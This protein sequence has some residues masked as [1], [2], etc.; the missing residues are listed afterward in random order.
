MK[1]ISKIY[2]LLITCFA[3]VISYG[4]QMYKPAHFERPRSMPIQSVP[5]S[6]TINVV[7]YGARP[8]DNKNDWPAICEVLAECERSGGGVRILFPKGI[9]QI[10]VGER[11]NQLTH[12]FSLSDVS[13]FM[14]EGDGATLILE[15]PDV[16]LMLLKNCQAGVIKGLTIDYKTLPF[17]QGVV[18]DVDINAKAFTFRS[19]GKGGR[20]TDDNFTKSKTKWGVLF[21][22]KNNRLLKDK[23]PNLVP[24]REVSNLDDKDLFRIVTT[25]NVIE[26]IAV[27]DPFAMI[28]RYNGCSTYSVNQCRQITFL[29]NVHYAGPAG[30][31]G[32]REST[33]ISV[34]NCKIQQKEDRL[35]SQNADCI[36]VTPSNEGPWIEGCL[37]E[38]QM[39]DA[40]NIKTELVYILKAIS[41]NQFLV[42]AKLRVNDELSLFNPREGRL[43]GTC[44]VLE[45]IPMDNATKI[46]VDARFENLQIGR[47]KTKDMF[48]NDSKSND[49]FVIKNNVFRNS[50]RY[51]M[52][53]QAKNG[54]IEGNTLENLSTGAITLQNSASWPEGFVPRNIVIE[55]NKIRNAGFDRSY[56]AEGKD[57]API[58]IRTTTANKKQAEWKGIRNIWIKNNEIISN[59]DHTIFLSGAQDIVIEKNWNNAQSNAPYYQENCD[60]VIIK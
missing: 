42:S 55:N 37:F 56:W 16:A 38:G 9:Y 43:I 30:S 21:D 34:V 57:I 59:S 26:Q 31:F 19:D 51:G 50:R 11:K 18:V 48:F 53:I 45:S 24:I 5:V 7:D 49:N 58:L 3:P 54:I 46:K 10:K 29:N 33:G 17:T 27:N 22:R 39:D 4:Q 12:A 52:L 41:D 6:K 44:R 35:I 20:P 14:I 8:D 15:N 23:A 2:L 32:L 47:D 36:H 13:N 28:A 40:I 60:N 25:Q 1:L